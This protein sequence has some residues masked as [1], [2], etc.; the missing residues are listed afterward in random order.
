LYRN[1]TLILCSAGGE[2]KVGKGRNKR[3]YVG[4]V[5]VGARTCAR[6]KTR[7]KMVTLRGVALLCALQVALH[8]HFV[9][10]QQVKNYV[11]N[12]ANVTDTWDHFFERCVGSGHAALALRAD[13]QV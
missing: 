11:V 7:K 12:T 13:Y 6:K 1:E 9:H 10:S 4:L 2:E 3:A 8:L 5:I